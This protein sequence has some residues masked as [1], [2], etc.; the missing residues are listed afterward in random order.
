MDDLSQAIGQYNWL[1]G[2]TY[3]SPAYQVTPDFGPYGVPYRMIGI[4]IQT[5][6]MDL[7]V[8]APTPYA[9]SAIFQPAGQYYNAGQY[10]FGQA[11]TQGIYTG[12]EST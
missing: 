1:P 5:C 9:A 7:G 2:A 10:G 6:V 3:P 12:V 11:P 8:E 4:P